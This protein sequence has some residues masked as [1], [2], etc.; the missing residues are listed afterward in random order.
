MV[1][2][3]TVFLPTVCAYG[4]VTPASRNDSTNVASQSTTSFVGMD[5]RPYYVF[6]S[7]KDDVLISMLDSDK[8]YKT[9]GNVSLHLKYGFTFSPL[10]KEGKIYPGAWQG[11]GTSVNFFGN[12]RG[13]GI[14]VCVYL[15]QGAPVWQISSVLSLYYEWNFGASFGWRP[16]DGHTATSSLITGSR[17]N[18]YI[19]IGGGVRWIFGNNWALTAG[20]DLTHFSNGNTSFPNPGMNMAGLRIGISRYF[21]KKDAFNSTI[22]AKKSAVYLSDNDSACGRKRYPGV[23]LTIYGAWR[24]RVYRGGET[25]VLLNGHFGIAGLDISPMWRITK[26][27]RAGVSADFQWDESSNLRRNHASG[28]TAEDLRFYRPSFFSQVSCGISGRAELVMPVFSVNV[29][30]GYNV[31]GPEEARASYQLANL[32]IRVAKGFFIN[33]GYQLLDFSKQSN[34]MLGVGY[35]FF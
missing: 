33:I 7:Y 18:A 24:K 25:P 1:A 29:G 14:P 9:I 5:V 34:L 2:C 30:I 23:D 19:N 27:F 22:T 20:I 31:V 17:M 12:S 26:N 21:G 35:S 8:A 4:V 6:P 10:S 11:A 32:K 15:F 16:C 13:T 28:S 3:V